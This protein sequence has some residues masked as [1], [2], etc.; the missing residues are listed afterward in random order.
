MNTFRNIANKIGSAVKTGFQRGAG[1]ATRALGRIGESLG[2]VASNTADFL[3]DSRSPARINTIRRNLGSVF[4]PFAITAASTPEIDERPAATRE[5]SLFA[6]LPPGFVEI[7]EPIP[8]GLVEYVLPDGKSVWRHTN[9]K[10]EN[11]INKRITSTNS[12]DKMTL[13]LES[14]VGIPR[15]YAKRVPREKKENEIQGAWFP[16]LL[17]EEIPMDLSR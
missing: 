10:F 11:V 1:I 9:E 2:S 16:Y 13:S 5:R 6:P 12:S 8:N 4:N 3:A 17:K 15:R 7:E 14:D